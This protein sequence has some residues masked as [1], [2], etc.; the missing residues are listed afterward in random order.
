MELSGGG[1]LSRI[2]GLGSDPWHCPRDK[3]KEAAAFSGNHSVGDTVPD[4]EPLSKSDGAI[5]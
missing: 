2:Q 1:Q 3:I 5:L 4:P